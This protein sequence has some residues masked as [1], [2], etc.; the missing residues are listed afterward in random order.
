MPSTLAALVIA[1]SLCMS[2]LYAALIIAHRRRIPFHNEN[3][4]HIPKVSIMLTLRNL[5]DG[6]EE[7]VASIFQSDYPDYDVYFAVDDMEDPCIKTVES[8]RT[9]FQKIRSVVVATGH[10]YTHNPKVNKLSR[11][12]RLSGATLFWILDS[13]VRV[14]PQTLRSLVSE[15]FKHDAKIVFSPIRCRGAKTMGSSI[16][17]SYVDY[18]MSG[19]ILFAWNLLR[20]RVIVGKSLLIE[21]KA[22]D[23]VGGFARF[24]DVLAED[25]WLG[26]IFAENGFAVRCNYTWVDNIKERS[27]I[28][29]YFDR[30]NRWAKLRFNLK[31]PVYLLEI[32]L[33][34]V[35]V[36]IFLSPFVKMNALP[37][38]SAVLFVR[39]FLE[40]M[41]FFAISDFD[42]KRLKAILSVAPAAIFKDLIMLIVYFIPFFSHTV[43]WRGGTIQIGKK[44]RITFNRENILY[45]KS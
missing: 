18:Y 43:R 7:N 27:T 5:D 40:Y 28:K 3:L 13:D 44:T 31:R 29:N 17:T 9:R 21:R 8:V 6:L 15:Y 41:V 33:N 11:L 45:D 38:L 23:R 36:V 25:Y 30:M 37:L 4:P 35:A 19:S 1:L 22:L 10:S 12:E 24:A 20:R 26:E 14:A 2:V 39:I 32:F 42:R 16:E 34:P